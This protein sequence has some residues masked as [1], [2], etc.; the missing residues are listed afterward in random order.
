MRALSVLSHALT[1]LG[2]ALSAFRVVVLIGKH[3]ERTIR[4]SCHYHLM[5]LSS[6]ASPLRK[7]AR[8]DGV[9][10]VEEGVSKCHK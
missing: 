5:V 6:I 8:D 1:P 2:Q 7:D 10:D 4:I 9:T 3:S